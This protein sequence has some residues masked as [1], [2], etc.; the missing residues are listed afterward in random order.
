MTGYKVDHWLQHL[1]TNVRILIDGRHENKGI[2]V[3]LCNRSCAF[4]WF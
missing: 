3:N 1:V 4:L 2:I